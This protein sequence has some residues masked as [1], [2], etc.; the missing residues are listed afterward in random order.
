MLSYICMYMVM[1]IILFQLLKNTT[2]STMQ[3]EINL[4]IQIHASAINLLFK[5]RLEKE[6]IY[7]QSS[8]SSSS[9]SRANN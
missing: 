2:P 9:S 4:S 5:H 1:N 8:S 7:I 3:L 6:Q